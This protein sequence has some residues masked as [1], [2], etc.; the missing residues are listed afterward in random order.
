MADLP[1]AAAVVAAEERLD[2]G[3]TPSTDEGRFVLGIADAAV[4]RVW[5]PIR[6]RVAGPLTGGTGLNG[7]SP[8]WRDACTN[9]KTRSV[10]F[11]HQYCS[12]STHRP[13]N[14]G[15]ACLVS[16]RRR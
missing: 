10:A 7:A 15:G 5:T 14:L 6:L 9:V 2:G 3:R 4:A 12:Q 1:A 16:C 13:R 8:A 11:R